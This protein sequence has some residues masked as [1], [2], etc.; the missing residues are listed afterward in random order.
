MYQIH[1]HSTSSL[2]FL[3]CFFF[4]CHSV[5]GCYIEFRR[6]SATAG[7][8]NEGDKKPGLPTSRVPTILRITQEKIAMTI[9]RLLQNSAIAA[10]TTKPGSSPVTITSPLSLH[11]LLQHI[12]MILLSS[13]LRTSQINLHHHPPHCRFPPLSTDTWYRNWRLVNPRAVCG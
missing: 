8:G 4:V 7:G 12:T 6:R 2:L 9:N 13:L 3:F 1:K 5:A 11:T 10:G